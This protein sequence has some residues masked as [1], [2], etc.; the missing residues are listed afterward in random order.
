MSRTRKAGLHIVFA[1]F[2]AIAT[3]V[4]AGVLGA[5]WWQGVLLFAAQGVAVFLGYN[6][7]VLGMAMVLESMAEDV[8]DEVENEVGGSSLISTMN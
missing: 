4:L 7:G 1:L 8:G 6:I 2:L 3:V 5:S